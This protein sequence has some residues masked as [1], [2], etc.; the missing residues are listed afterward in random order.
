M[1]QTLWAVVQDGKIQLSEPVALPEGAKVLVTLLSAED[2]GFWLRAAEKSL[3]AVWDN[4][5]DDAY[6]ELLEG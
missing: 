3:A 6:A 1:L 2:E 4:S 5:E